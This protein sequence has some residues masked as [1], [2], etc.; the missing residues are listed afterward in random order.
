MSIFSS[1]IFVSVKKF[2][3]DNINSIIR[4]VF[5]L[6]VCCMLAGISLLLGDYG[7]SFKFRLPLGIDIAF[8]GALFMFVGHGLSRLEI[9]SNLANIIL[10]IGLFIFGFLLY[11]FNLP[12]SKEINLP[13]VEMAIGAYGN[14][15][16]FILNSTL[17]SFA[18]ILFSKQI[19][20]KVLEFLGRN[21]L[22]NLIVSSLLITVSKY[23]ITS[24][25]PSLNSLLFSS[26]VTF[27]TILI[28]IP[29]I[30]GLNYFVPNVV[31]QK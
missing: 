28:S 19:S 25:L 18:V 31:G 13:H 24:V 22:T 10:M 14:Y 4:L 1:I 8:S 16:L 6:L 26:I 30:I 15:Y 21:S 5:I 17:I 2:I 27:L 29:F 20:F 12:I 11:R 7:D 9:S 23:I 3:D